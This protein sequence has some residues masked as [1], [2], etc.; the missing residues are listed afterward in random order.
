M[1]EE[2]GRSGAYEA[3]LVE[4]VQAWPTTIAALRWPEAFPTSG[5]SLHLVGE[6]R[7]RWQASA[8]SPQPSALQPVLLAIMA[9]NSAAAASPA[10]QALGPDLGP[11]YVAVMGC[12][13]DAR[14]LLDGAPPTVY[15]SATYWSL[16]IRQ[17]ALEGT[18]DDEAHRVYQIMT[19]SDLAPIHAD[20]TLNLLLENVSDGYSADRWGYRRT[21][22]TWPSYG[23]LPSPWPADTRWTTL[24]SDAVTTADLRSV[25]TECP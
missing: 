17:A 2:A 14:D 16:A 23:S 7:D 20:A 25:L 22:I 6:A 12:Q 4:V 24:P 13:Q 10:D 11:I 5:G 9:G 8:P 18:W 3:N 21:P 1:N 15:R 19:G